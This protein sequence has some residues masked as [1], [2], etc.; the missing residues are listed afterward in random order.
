MGLILVLAHT[1]TPARLESA[2][3]RYQIV[4]APAS[5]D[6]GVQVLRLDTVTGRAWLKAIVI[7]NG[8]KKVA[9]GVI[10]DSPEPK[11]R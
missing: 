1:Q 3:G 11:Q 6:E 9:W 2:L 7:D 4:V 5:S 8:V 10:P